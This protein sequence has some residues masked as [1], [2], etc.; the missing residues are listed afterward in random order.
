MGVATSQISI[1]HPV[2]L[3]WQ[4]FHQRSLSSRIAGRAFD[5]PVAER[6][7]DAQGIPTPSSQ[8]RLEAEFQ[9]VEIQKANGR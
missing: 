4:W 2:R 1:R 3:E 8:E 9:G 6:L 5:S 7:V